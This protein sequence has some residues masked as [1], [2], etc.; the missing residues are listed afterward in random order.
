MTDGC[1]TTWFSNGRQRWAAS[2]AE[3]GPYL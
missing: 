2:S 3:G 1:E